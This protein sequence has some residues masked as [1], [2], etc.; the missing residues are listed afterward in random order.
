MYWSIGLGL[1]PPRVQIDATKIAA[2]GGYK[3]TASLG[4]TKKVTWRLEGLGGRI[5]NTSRSGGIRQAIS[6][7]HPT[8]CDARPGM[9]KFLSPL[10]R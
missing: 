10:P 6:T 3:T 1:T 8:T 5:I 7:S 4:P 2:V 9:E